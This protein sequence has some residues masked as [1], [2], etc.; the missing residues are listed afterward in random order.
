MKAKAL[1]VFIVTDALSCFNVGKTMN[2]TQIAL[3]VELILEEY[4]FLK[5][6][7]FKL[8]FKQAVMCVYGQVYDRIDV[9]VICSWLQQYCNDRALCADIISYQEHIQVK[10]RRND[11]EKLLYETKKVI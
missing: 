10:E 2:D 9:Q 11:N 1:L 6:D 7:D 4:Y 3:M 5:P 8:M